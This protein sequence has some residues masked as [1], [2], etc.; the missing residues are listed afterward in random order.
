MREFVVTLQTGYRVTVRADRMVLPDYHANSHLRLVVDGG[1]AGDSTPLV[2]ALFEGTAVASVVARDH[3]V[4]ED[5]VEP[6]QV[7]AKADGDIPF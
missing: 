1:S 7:I 3:L 5:R 2:V 4:S 6:V